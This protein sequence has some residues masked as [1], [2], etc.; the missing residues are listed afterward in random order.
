MPYTLR[1]DIVYNALT[2]IAKIPELKYRIYL[3][4]GLGL[5]F[6][7]CL[8][9]L[10]NLLRPTNDADFGA[11]PPLRNHEVEKI[12]GE[13]YFKDGKRGKDREGFYIRI[14]KEQDPFFLHFERPTQ[15]HWERIKESRTRGHKNAQIFRLGD[16]ELRVVRLEDIY[17]AKCRR[18]GYVSRRYGIDI[19]IIDDPEE[20]LKHLEE[21]RNSLSSYFEASIEAGSQQ[22]LL[23]NAKKDIFDL[24]LIA[25]LIKMGMD[26]DEK[27]VKEIL[28]N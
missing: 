14:G 21:Q 17:A 26:F 24:W 2:E 9:E 3:A 8:A 15:R 5:Q 4:G 7:V 28:N 16:S 12:Y 19:P 6:Y 22:R 20:Y 13:P 25:I 10:L 18:V 27:Y 1:D 11:V 23:Y